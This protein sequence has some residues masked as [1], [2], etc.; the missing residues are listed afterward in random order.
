MVTFDEKIGCAKFFRNRLIF[1]GRALRYKFTMGTAIRAR[2]RLKTARFWAARPC[3]PHHFPHHLKLISTQLL[4]AFRTNHN[5]SLVVKNERL[6]INN[7]DKRGKSGVR[8][9]IK[10]KYCYVARFSDTKARFTENDLKN[11]GIEIN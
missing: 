9:V 2:S 11:I 5:R 1:R 4:C 6:K 10:R 3:C 8:G 7:L